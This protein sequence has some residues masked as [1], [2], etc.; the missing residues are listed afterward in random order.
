MTVISAVFIL[1]PFII[2]T[3]AFIKHFYIFNRMFSPYMDKHHAEEWARMKDDTG[4]F[5]PQYA[6]FYHSKAIY[7][8]IWNSS[9]TFG[10]NNIGAY[11]KKMKTIAWEIPV[12]FVM[13]MLIVV[14]VGLWRCCF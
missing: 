13:G 6:S 14:A 7:D 4:W 3:G 10:D 11:R 8:F 2:L 12:A 9:E 5:R 1:L